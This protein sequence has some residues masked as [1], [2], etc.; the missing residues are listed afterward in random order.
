MIIRKILLNQTISK[1]FMFVVIA[2]IQLKKGLESEFKNWIVESNKILANF[3]GFVGRRLL[4]SHTGK[5]LMLVEFE[6]KEKFEK[7]HQSAEHARIQSKSHSYMD[8]LP[9]PKFYNVTSQ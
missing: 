6:S 3:D 2:E 7:M 1:N 5:H 4:E 9:Q 8:G